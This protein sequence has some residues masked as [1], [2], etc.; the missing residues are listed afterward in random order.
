MMSG[1]TGAPRDR[2]FT[3]VLLVVTILHAASADTATDRVSNFVN[4]YLKKNQIPGC[5]VMVRHDGKVVLCQ[6][7]GVA[8]V[9]H[10]V[11]VTP[12]TV[13]QSGSIG[14][15]F[16]AMAIMMLIEEQ[17]LALEDP[18]SKYLDV[19]ENWSAIRVRHLLTHT[20]G[21]GDYPESFSLQ[22]DY[23]EDEL[24]KMITAQPLAFAPG[25]KWS[26]S[27]LGYVT[28]GILIHKVSGEFWGDFL[29]QRVFAP[30]GMKHT[31]V[32]SEA[33]IIPNRAAGYVLKNGALKNQQWVSP[34]VNN[35]ADGSLYFTVEDLAKWDEALE[36]RKLISRAS[37]EQMWTPV[38]LNNG[39]T[40]PYGF[41]WRIA[42]TD[43]GHGVLEHGGAWQGFASYIVRYPEDRLTVAVL[44]NRAGAS[45]S[46]IAK[47]IAG[48]YVPSV[49]PRVRTA[50][51]LDPA[52]LSSYTG[53]YRLEDRFTI[54]VSV[55]GDRLET[56][57]LGEKI[58]AASRIGNGLFSGRFRSD[59]SF[60]E[61]CR[62]QSHVADHL[63]A[64]RAGV[65]QGTVKQTATRNF[66]MENFICVQCGTQF[67]ETV[68]PPSRCL[69]M[70]GLAMLFGASRGAWFA[71]CVDARRAFRSGPRVSK[72]ARHRDHRHAR[73]FDGTAGSCVGA[74]SL[75]CDHRTR[76]LRR[77]SFCFV[78]FSRAA[79][80]KQAILPARVAAL[81]QADRIVC[82]TVLPS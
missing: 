46:Y 19:P 79:D 15:Q 2:R 42:K 53:E 80:V 43:S 63:R 14:K 37:Y 59:I 11:R 9:E 39:T 50:I 32:I 22:R 29:Q 54:K 51:K 34:T 36:T 74:Q 82:V 40:A 20:S 12:Q 68:E 66:L 48:F 41:G 3:L 78:L 28:L 57:W 72:P 52:I 49:A 17:K 1:M 73:H 47:R 65:A 13:F 31:R 18:I 16:T 6:G 67:G 26:Y 71:A 5:A 27:N 56:M 35:T 24:L 58:A 8:N 23:T 69:L 77:E 45:A 64:G 62:R 44:C 76:T 81:K 10:G 33:D 25:E 4:E 7:Y 75:G 61:R 38:K 70:Q 30:L 60:R 21:L 55:A